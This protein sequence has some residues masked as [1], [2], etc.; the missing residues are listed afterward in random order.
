ALID[1]VNQFGAAL[2]DPDGDQVEPIHTCIAIGP[3]GG[4]T[5]EELE[6]SSS[7]VSLSDGVLRGETAAIVA[8]VLMDAMRRENS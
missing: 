8:G 2:A 5:P 6:L 4:F 7:Q 1:V 3:E